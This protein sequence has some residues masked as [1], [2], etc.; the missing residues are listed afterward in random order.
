M[1]RRQRPNEFARKVNRAMAVSPRHERA[2]LSHFFSQQQDVGA[3]DRMLS[4]DHNLIVLLVEEAG[5][6]VLLPN[7]YDFDRWIGSISIEPTKNPKQILVRA[8]RGAGPV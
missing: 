7:E 5:G 6:R 8:K 3:L 1:N 4:R 2:Y